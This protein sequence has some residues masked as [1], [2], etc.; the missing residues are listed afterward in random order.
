M[1]TLRTS[2]FQEENEGCVAK[3]LE[4]AWRMRNGDQAG[5][6]SPTT[7]QLLGIDVIELAS[8]QLPC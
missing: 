8:M 4:N 5:A 6:I 3:R 7:I 2:I 1:A